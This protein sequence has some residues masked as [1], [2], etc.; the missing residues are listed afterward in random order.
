MPT[1]WVS[2]EVLEHALTT[3]G[4]DKLNPEEAAELLSTIDAEGVGK[5]NYQN[6]VQMMTQG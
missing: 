2:T 4:S 6:F 3:Y 5:I 1:G